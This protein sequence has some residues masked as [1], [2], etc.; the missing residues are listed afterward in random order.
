MQFFKKL[1]E[2]INIIK[3]IYY[4]GLCHSHYFPSGCPDYQEVG[5]KEVTWS[6]RSGLA[7]TQA[8]L[9]EVQR[10]SSVAPIIPRQAAK[11]ASL[12]GYL[13]PKGTELFLNFW[14]VVLVWP[15]KPYKQAAAK[16]IMYIG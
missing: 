4:N 13:L 15:A 7:Y 8:A 2:I 12:D 1:K 11:D 10:M 14:Y 5:N 3:C 9:L 6:H 16:K